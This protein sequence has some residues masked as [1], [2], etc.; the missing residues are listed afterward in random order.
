MERSPHI[1]HTGIW[2]RAKIVCDGSH[3][4]AREPYVPYNVFGYYFSP[5]GA[6][7]IEPSLPY[8]FLNVNSKDPEAIVRFSERFGLLFDQTPRLVIPHE[9]HDGR[10]EWETNHTD[11][12]P[13]YGQHLSAGRSLELQG[14]IPSGRLE[15]GSFC[16]AQDRMRSMV[17]KMMRSATLLEARQILSRHLSR[18]HSGRPSLVW[19]NE[20]ERWTTMWNIATLEVAMYLMLHLDLQRGGRILLCQSRRCAKWFLADHPGTAFCSVRCKTL[21]RYNGTEPGRR[22]LIFLDR[23]EYR[24]NIPNT[25]WSILLLSRSAFLM[26]NE[27]HR[28]NS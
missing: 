2:W 11:P 6:F 28:C 23:L 4:T 1:H 3:L 15:I 26:S 10:S 13:P 24:S 5:R 22:G 17:L 21:T 12:I 16:R 18:N 25:R 27:A 8:I 20:G 9:K 14:V 19:D 7:R